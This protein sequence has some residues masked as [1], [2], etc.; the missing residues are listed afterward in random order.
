MHN[1][2][3]SSIGHLS[4]RLLLRRK[5]IEADFEEIFR[6]AALTGT[7]LEINASPDRLDLKDLHVNRARELGIPLV[8]NSDAHTAEMLQNQRLGVAIARRGWCESKHI[9]NTRSADEL[10][11]YLRM[12]K[13]ERAKGFSNS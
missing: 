3:V 5:P 7:A 9:L 8:I 6:M 13:P 12:E 2:H 1:P 4:T 11:A 10:V